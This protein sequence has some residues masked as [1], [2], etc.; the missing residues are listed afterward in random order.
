MLFLALLEAM[1]AHLYLFDCSLIARDFVA[2][3]LSLTLLITP[4]WGARSASF[5]TGVFADRAHVGSTL[6]SVGATVFSGDRL[7]TAHVGSVQ[8]RPGASRLRVS[9]VSCCTC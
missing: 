5:G 9:G 6:A 1:M 3:L 4:L 8:V 2:T 7:R